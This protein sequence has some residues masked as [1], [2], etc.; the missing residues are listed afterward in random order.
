MDAIDIEGSACGNEGAGHGVLYLIP[1]PI[2]PAGAG[3][4]LTPFGLSQIGHLRHFVVE[5]VRPS[6]RF[7]ARLGLDSAVDEMEFYPTQGGDGEAAFGRALGLLRSGVDVGLLSDAG[8]PCIADPGAVLV[9]RAHRVGIG[10]VPLVGPS[11]ILLTLMSSGLPAQR[12]RFCGYLPI[13]S[14]QRRRAILELQGRAQREGETQLFIET[15]YRNAQMLSSLLDSLHGET[16]LCVGY[17]IH[18]PEGFIVTRSVGEWRSESV[19]LGRIPA[20]FGIGVRV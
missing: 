2:G 15:P 8:L 9:A 4:T 11:S 7:L 20:V 16:L 6:R 3:D 10:I 17:G 1:T 5:S 14:A 18:H 13:P 12:F 19:Q